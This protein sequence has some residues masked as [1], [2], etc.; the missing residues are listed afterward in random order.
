MGTLRT[1]TNYQVSVNG[2]HSLSKEGYS[3]YTYRYS[4]YFNG[5]LPY[6]Q[7]YGK[8]QAIEHI[9][10]YLG[11]VNEYQEQRRNETLTIEKVVTIVELV[12]YTPMAPIPIKG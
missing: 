9:A 7:V 12:D 3:K 11:Q 5:L 2:H 4:Q 8:E 6:E 10:E 1:V